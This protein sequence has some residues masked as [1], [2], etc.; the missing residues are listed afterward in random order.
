MNTL[1]EQTGQ[2]LIIALERL[3]VAIEGGA[4]ALET[5]EAR[6]YVARSIIDGPEGAIAE[7]KRNRVRRTRAI[8]KGTP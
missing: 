3:A 6:A 4:V 2:L 1:T 7:N 5:R 8:R